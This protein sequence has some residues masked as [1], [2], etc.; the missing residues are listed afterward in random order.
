MPERA[1][2]LHLALRHRLDAGSDGLG[3][4]GAADEA[5]GQG[6]DAEVAE[7]DLV[8]AGRRWD[9]PDAEG[10]EDDQRRQAPEELDDRRSRSTGRARRSRA[11]SGPGPARAARPKTKPQAV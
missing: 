8:A 4:V 10:D 3:H 9:E 7:G 6:D 1:G 5:Q 11:A 2:R